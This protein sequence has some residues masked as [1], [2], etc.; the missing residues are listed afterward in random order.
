MAILLA[1]PDRNVEP[2]VAELRTKAADLDFRIW[3]ECGEVNEI[4]FA[5]VWRHPPE[6]LGQL[7]NLKAV[8]SFGAGAEHL[9]SDPCLPEQL[10]IGRLAGSRLASDMAAYLVAQVFSHWRDL[11]RFRRQQQK[12]CWSPWAPVRAPKIGLLGLGQMGLAALRAFT[13]LG[14]PVQ[15]FNRDGSDL[16]GL[17]VQAGPSGLHELAAWCDYLICLL[18]L[19][20]ETRGILNTSLFAKMQSHAVVVNVGRGAHLIEKDLLAALDADALGGAILDVFEH[21]P[22]PSDHPFWTHPRITL[23]PHCASTTSAAEA[24]DLIIASYRNILA[25]DGPLNPVDRTRG[26]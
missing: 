3:P 19:T 11:P 25:G 10:P 15:G 6:L 4:D 8:S 16:P 9:L 23:T 24:A 21:E 12:H 7:P 20:G 26:Y 5:V 2:L 14:A 13:V 17:Q 18:P 1:I 22:L